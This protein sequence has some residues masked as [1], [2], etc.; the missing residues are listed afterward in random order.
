MAT[1]PRE[2]E[3]LCL[4]SFSSISDSERHYFIFMVHCSVGFI[5]VRLQELVSWFMSNYLPVS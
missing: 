5:A 3:Y 4:I 1:N 2:L